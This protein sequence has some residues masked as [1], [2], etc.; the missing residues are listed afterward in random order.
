MK[1]SDALLDMNT[2]ANKPHKTYLHEHFVIL[3]ICFHTA[4]TQPTLMQ[5]N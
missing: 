3:V 1:Q 4:K 5:P 2:P